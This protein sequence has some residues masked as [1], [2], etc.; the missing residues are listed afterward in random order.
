MRPIRAFFYFMDTEIWMDVVGYEGFYE[1]SNLGRVKSLPRTRKSSKGGIASVKG[2]ILKYKIDRYG[3]LVYGLSKDGRGK[4]H[5][6]H[7]IVAKTFIPNPENLPQVNHIDGNKVNNKVENLEWCTNIYNHMEAL[8]LGLR[9]GKPYKKRVDARNVLMYKDGVHIRTFESLA[10]A[11]RELNFKKGRISNCLR[12][13][14]KSSGGFFFEYEAKNP[15]N[16]SN[17][18]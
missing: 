5:T 9:G 16:C 6:C 2:K 10:Q 3:Y 8:K 13:S 1:V 12:K 11:A 14:S 15:S 18:F 4:S 17:G 7:R